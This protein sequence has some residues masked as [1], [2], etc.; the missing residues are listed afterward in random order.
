MRV[1][2]DTAPGAPAAG[3][4]KVALQSMYFHMAGGE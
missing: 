2:L 4:G 3:P 1:H